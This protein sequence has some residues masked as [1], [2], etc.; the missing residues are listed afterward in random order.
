MANRTVASHNPRSRFLAPLIALDMNLSW[1]RRVRPTNVSIT[2]KSQLGSMDKTIA[3]G[4]NASLSITY[5]EG[6]NA[7]NSMTARTQALDQIERKAEDGVGIR[8]GV[9][10][11]LR[12]HAPYCACYQTQ[13]L[14]AKVS[15]RAA[16]CAPRFLPSNRPRTQDQ[17]LGQV[18]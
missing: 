7:K 16:A 12:P 2:P 14:R 18:R 15:S 8:C 9:K 11:A 13:V 6:I 1:L 4:P 3:S 5:A 10:M 17:R